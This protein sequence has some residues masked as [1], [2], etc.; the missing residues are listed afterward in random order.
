MTCLNC[1]KDNINNAIF[2]TQC[3]ANLK[4]QTNNNQQQNSKKNNNSILYI[5]IIGVVLLIMMISIFFVIKFINNVNNKID[6]FKKNIID[7]PNNIV[8]IITENIEE[9]TDF[10][11]CKSTNCHTVTIYFSENN[12]TNKLN[13]SHKSFSVDD[14]AKIDIYEFIN[15]INNAI[16]VDL[17][18]TDGESFKI[19]INNFYIDIAWYYKDTETKFDF[20]KPITEDTNIEMKLLD[21]TFNKESIIDM[22]GLFNKYKEN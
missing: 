9:N 1:G 7:N 8:D 17:I 2:C 3:G 22:N 18:T 20:N 10:L 5:T 15:K 19:G 11:T 4:E 14:G 21:G 13:E 16:G 12:S 6:T